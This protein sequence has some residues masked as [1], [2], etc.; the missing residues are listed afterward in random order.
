MLHV[1]L[2]PKLERQLAEVAAR[3]G[4]A[5][6]EIARKAL[7]A[8]LEELEDYATAVEAWKEHDPAATK[9]S[10]EMLRELG[11]ED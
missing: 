6:D 10:E 8:Y 3:I 5:P 7:L 1:A 9:S 2:D 11:L 4:Q